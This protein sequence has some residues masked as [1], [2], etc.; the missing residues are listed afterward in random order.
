M[1]KYSVDFDLKRRYYATVASNEDN[2]YVTAFHIRAESL[3][4]AL[5]IAENWCSDN[6]E[7]CRVA[8]ISEEG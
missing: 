1:A 2:A 6:Y 5:V 8:D 7:N 3:S 4:A